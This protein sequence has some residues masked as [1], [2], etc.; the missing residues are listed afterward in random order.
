MYDQQQVNLR[1]PGDL[2]DRAEQRAGE[3]GISRNEWMVRAL[4]W[5]LDQPVTDRP[6]SVKERV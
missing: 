5:A 6:T 1:I 2:K 3:I 4:R